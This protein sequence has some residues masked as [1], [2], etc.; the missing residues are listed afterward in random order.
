[1]ASYFPFVIIF[2]FVHRAPVISLQCRSTPTKN[3]TSSDLDELL[4]LAYA[5]VVPSK[6]SLVNYSATESLGNHDSV[7]IETSS[8]EASPPLLVEEELADVEF[9]T[10]ATASEPLSP[11]LPLLSEPVQGEVPDAATPAEPLPSTVETDSEE[12]AADT[13]LHHWH[14]VGT[15]TEKLIAKGPPRVPILCLYSHGR[16]TPGR[17]TYGDGDRSFDVPL[18]VDQDD[19][20]GTVALKS[21]RLCADWSKRLQ[22]R[23]KVKAFA[24][25]SHFD[26]LRDTAVV[27]A[28]MEQLQQDVLKT[29]TDRDCID[30][31]GYFSA[32]W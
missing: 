20:D 21:L 6:A 11:E 26:M 30:A 17:I 3:Y 27:D 15:S 32:F 28:V 22:G 24:N 16:P 9:E 5:Q 13:M 25:V 4:A 12:Y 29:C 14:T 19:G 2:R 23:L 1:V 8:E 18:R 31:A 10:M 7:A